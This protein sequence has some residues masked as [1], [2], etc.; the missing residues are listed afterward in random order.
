MTTKC[1]PLRTASISR[2]LFLRGVSAPLVLLPHFWAARAGAAAKPYAARI[3]SAGFDGESYQGGLHLTLAPGWKTYW[4]VPGEGGI[5]PSLDAKGGNIASFSFTCPLP[6]RIPSEGGEAIGYKDEV[7]FPWRLVPTDPSQPVAASLSA[8]VGVCETVCIPV[9]VSQD[10]ALAPVGM[11]T[12]D[13]ALLAGWL[14]KVPGEGK[15]V[16]N[17]TAGEAGGI[18]I[19]VDLSAPAQDIFVEGS[20]MH[21]FLAP[22]WEEGRRRARLMVH[23]AKSVAELRNKPLRMTFVTEAGKAAGGLEQTVMVS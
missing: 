14:A 16:A 21:F 17:V 18:F 10:L 19:D 6:H 1:P 22:V 5:P 2:R 20:I 11:A 15:I 3:F 4:R 13:T 9:P 8:F 23:G 12:R 7:I